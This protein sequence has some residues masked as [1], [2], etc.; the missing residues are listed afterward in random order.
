M[1][2]FI[3]RMLEENQTFEEFV[4]AHAKLMYGE[5]LPE[6]EYYGSDIKLYQEKIKKFQNMTENEKIEY[7]EKLKKS[8]IQDFEYSLKINQNNFQKFENMLEK[9]QNWNSTEEFQCLKNQ[10]ECNLSGAINFLN[11]TN[12]E[13]LHE[14]DEI[15]DASSTEFYEKELNLG[16]DDLKRTL[17]NQKNQK[18]RNENKLN[19]KIENLKKLIPK[20][21]SKQ[22]RNDDG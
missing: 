1:D 19:N 16:I 22:R 3:E 9:V 4:W 13:I 18:K 12:L 8:K 6:F 11:Q 20:I 5:Q 21:E 7:T 10:M 14:I 15:K 2:Y 17:E